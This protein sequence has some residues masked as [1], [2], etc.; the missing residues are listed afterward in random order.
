ML[1]TYIDLKC[2]ELDVEDCIKIFDDAL[3]DFF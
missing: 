2:S 3:N 1:E